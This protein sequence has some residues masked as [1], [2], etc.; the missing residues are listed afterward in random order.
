MKGLVTLIKFHQRTLDDL[1]RKMAAL[2]NQKS[3]LLLLSAK[4]REE[5]ASEIKQASKNPEMGSF[6]GDFS[7]RMQ[8]R[9]EE[10]AGEVRQLEK[11]MAELNIHIIEAFSEL[12]KFEIALDNAKKRAEAEEKR[13]EAIQMD[14]IAE[15]QHR[16][17]MEEQ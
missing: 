14:E 10:I 13:K 4:L 9:Q 16:R 12:K 15:Q 8:K 2:E 11:Q 6:F 5:L 7:K 17:K 1:R 3:Q